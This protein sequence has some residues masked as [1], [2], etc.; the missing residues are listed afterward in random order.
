MNCVEIL[1]RKTF[2]VDFNESKWSHNCNTFSCIL[3]ECRK[4][5]SLRHCNKPQAHLI[6]PTLIY[7][8]MNWQ[9]SS[10]V[11]QLCWNFVGRWLE[12][13][14]QLFKLLLINFVIDIT[15]FLLWSQKCIKHH[16]LLALKF[17]NLI[18]FNLMISVAYVNRER[19]MTFMK[20]CKCKYVRVM[21]SK[22]A[23]KCK[24]YKQTLTR[25]HRRCFHSIPTMKLKI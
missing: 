23:G 7:W 11:L 4:H 1:T 8:V 25:T 13:L 6:I 15:L 16:H 24:I 20:L 19:D 5:F 3:V 17:F 14:F 18:C 9:R 10:A 2:W 22:H 12:N 21:A